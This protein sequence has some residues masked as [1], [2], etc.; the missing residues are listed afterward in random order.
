MR[1]VFIIRSFF[2]HKGKK[3]F[4]PYSFI[5]VCSLSSGY[6]RGWVA[7]QICARYFI[8]MSQFQICD[9][10]FQLST[11]VFKKMLNKA[12]QFCKFEKKYQSSNFESCGCDCNHENWLAMQV[13]CENSFELRICERCNATQNLWFMISTISKSICTILKRH[14]ISVDLKIMLLKCTYF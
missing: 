12:R 10:T 14:Q 6:D 5:L 8:N 11:Y 4:P 7:T 13:V 9:H 1:K 3:I 2:M